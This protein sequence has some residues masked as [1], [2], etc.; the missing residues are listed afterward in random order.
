MEACLLELQR[1]GY[2]ILDLSQFKIR[3][4]EKNEHGIVAL[5]ERLAPENEN[6]MVSLVQKPLLRSQPLVQGQATGTK[7]SVKLKNLHPVGLEFMSSCLTRSSIATPPTQ[8]M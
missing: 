2:L 3:A 6:D 7:G 5:C 8:H 4:L 1:H